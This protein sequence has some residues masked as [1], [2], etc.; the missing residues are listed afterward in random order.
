MQE[1]QI[2][3]SKEPLWKLIVSGLIIS[4]MFY[5]VKWVGGMDCV[6]IAGFTALLL[7]KK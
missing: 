5:F 6:I 4:G 2:P 3:L 7:N 1:Q